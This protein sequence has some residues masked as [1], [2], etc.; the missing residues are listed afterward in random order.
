MLTSNEKK[1]V[2]ENFENEKNCLT[3]FGD[4]AQLQEENAGN[5]QEV[6]L[7]NFTSDGTITGIV[8]NVNYNQENGTM[9]LDMICEG[10]HR[11]LMLDNAYKSELLKIR[12]DLIKSGDTRDNVNFEFIISKPFLLKVVDNLIIELK[13]LDTKL[14]E[15]TYYIFEKLMEE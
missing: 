14:Y 3:F 15:S 8:T 11:Y 2:K 5:P 12:N 4:V 1:I 9:T 10:S 6:D 7:Q 13:P